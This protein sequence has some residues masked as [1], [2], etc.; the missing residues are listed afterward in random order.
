MLHLVVELT[1]SCRKFTLKAVRKHPVCLFELLNWLKTYRKSKKLSMLLDLWNIQKPQNLL[2]N[3]EAYQWL[4][5]LS[6]MKNFATLVG[7]LATIELSVKSI[8]CTWLFVTLGLIIIPAFRKRIRLIRYVFNAVKIGKHTNG[9]TLD[10][11]WNIRSL[12]HF[13]YQT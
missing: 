13:T 5:Q 1:N 7:K 4:P 9:K 2:L 6:N 11:F 3:P 10:H 12:I 8:G